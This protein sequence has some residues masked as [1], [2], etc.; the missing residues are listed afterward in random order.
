[1]ASSAEEGDSDS[2]SNDEAPPMSEV[3]AAAERIDSRLCL[4]FAR[5]EGE[6]VSTLR[7]L[8]RRSPSALRLYAQHATFDATMSLDDA[9]EGRVPVV[10]DA[11]PR[12]MSYTDAGGHALVER[13][14]PAD[15]SVV[16]SVMVVGYD[17]TRM[18]IETRWRFDGAHREFV[19][20]AG[21]SV[22]NC[23]AFEMLN[24]SYIY[25]RGDVRFCSLDALGFDERAFFANIAQPNPSRPSSEQLVS[26]SYRYAPLLC[27]VVR[28]QSL[29]L[30][31]D[32]TLRS[33]LPGDRAYVPLRGS[34]HFAFDRERLARATH[35][36]STALAQGNNVVCGNGSS[37]ATL[38][39][40]AE[41]FT[42]DVWA[43]AATTRR[44]N[45]QQRRG[46]TSTFVDSALRASL[47]LIIVV[48]QK[49]RQA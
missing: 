23:D 6:Y 24:Q 38:V 15:Y 9:E 31:S 26:R 1:M 14:E 18:P 25:R 44:R 11:T 27:Q 35:F 2:T 3:R 21:V 33:S 43:G 22:V 48:A 30:D 46:Q 19:L 28:A 34:S 13:V 36:I 42:H 41:P 12:S 49:S 5:S 39:L 47:T 4:L 7:D 40:H 37:G 10:L 45:L 17:S 20:P 32:A 29:E 8:E 16:V